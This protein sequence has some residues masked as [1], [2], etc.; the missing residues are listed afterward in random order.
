M[1]S[2]HKSAMHH[3]ILK[4]E[5][6]NK[7]YR[8]LVLKNKLKVLLSSDPTTEKAGVSMSVAVGKDA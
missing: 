6:D 2:Q 3:Q 7:S 5:N 1:E 8:D 4:S